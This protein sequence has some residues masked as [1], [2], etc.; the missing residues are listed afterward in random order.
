MKRLL[1]FAL[2][3]HGKPAGSWIILVLL[4]I[5]G[6]AAGVTKG[7]EGTT[8]FWEEFHRPPESYRGPPRSGRQIYDLHCRACHGKG[9]QGAPMPGD[10]YEWGRRRQQGVES[11]LVHAINGFGR[12]LMPPR[13]GCG[14]CSDAE[15]RAAIL[16]MLERSGFRAGDPR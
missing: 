13:G 10:G 12:G 8:G 3:G 11:L 7:S 2:I 16:Y 6:L 1:Q 14:N 9:T 4:V 5:P 15:L